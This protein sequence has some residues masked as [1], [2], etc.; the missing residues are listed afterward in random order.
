MDFHIE[1][2]VWSEPANDQRLN[3]V[4]DTRLRL[5]SFPFLRNDCVSLLLYLI[6]PCS[7]PFIKSD[8]LLLLNP[9]CTP[10]LLPLGIE[11]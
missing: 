2:K 5:H 1:A 11:H 9:R 10:C 8:A 6:R 3:F 4:I 7:F